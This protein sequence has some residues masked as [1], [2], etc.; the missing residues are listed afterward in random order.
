MSQDPT[1]I[2]RWKF[3]ANGSSVVIETDGED[4]FS[5]RAKASTWLGASPTALEWERTAARPD[6]SLRWVGQDF[7][8]G[9]PKHLEIKVRGGEWEPA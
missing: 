8:K 9:N 6:V 4:F 3:K 7:T 1:H 5:A 2:N